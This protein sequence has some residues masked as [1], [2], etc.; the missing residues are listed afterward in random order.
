MNLYLVR[1]NGLWIGGKAFVWAD[2]IVEAIEKVKNH[3]GTTN[4]DTPI[5]SQCEMTGVIYNDNGDY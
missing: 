1:Y 5:V 4:F 2:S 3:Q